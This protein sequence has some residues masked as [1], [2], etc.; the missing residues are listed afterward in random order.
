MI[1]NGV[2]MVPRD[3]TERSIIKDLNISNNLSMSHFNYDRKKQFISERKELDRYNKNK[4]I[5]NI[6]AESPHANI[7]SLSG[8]NQQKVIFARWFE[9]DSDIYILDNPTQGIDV[10][11]KDEIYEL[12]VHAAKQ[13]KG[14]IVFTSEV[15]EIQ[16]IANRC[17][18][19]Y[20]GEINKIL[21]HHEINEV[22][23][24]Y[25]STGANKKENHNG[26]S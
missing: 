22:D 8:G 20:K 23:V 19:M 11:S 2:S 24:M 12:I 15:P 13:G 25:Y 4:S 3:R 9:I 6:K 7:S 26:R 21:D 18:V 10:G 14:L 1:Q 16:K 17:I 5:F